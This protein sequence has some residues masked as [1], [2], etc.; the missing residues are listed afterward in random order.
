MH[1]CMRAAMWLGTCGLL[2]AGEFVTKSTTHST[3]KLQHLS[4]Y[5]AD[6]HQLD[7]LHL[8]DEFPAYMSLRLDQSKT[9]PFRHGTNVAIGNVSAINYMLNYLQFRNQSLNRL[10]LFVGADGQALTAGALVKF[11]QSL[12]EKA[13][14]PM[15]ISFWATHF[16]KEE[17]PL[18]TK[19]AC[20]TH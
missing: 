2:R 16:A 9:D 18:Y 14:I 10:P 5:D 12:I 7:P 3:L 6:D 17:L 1:L 11:T 8:N 15:L 13:N 4:F 20:L 19:P